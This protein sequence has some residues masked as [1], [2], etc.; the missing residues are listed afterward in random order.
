MDDQDQINGK[1][2]VSLNARACAAT[3]ERLPGFTAWR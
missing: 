3:F 1:K 2:F